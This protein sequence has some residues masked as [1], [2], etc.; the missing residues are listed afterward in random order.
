MCLHAPYHADA[1]L[2]YELLFGSTNALLP[3]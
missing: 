2:A 3:W 1:T